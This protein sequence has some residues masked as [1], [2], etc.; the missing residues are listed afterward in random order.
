MWNHVYV[1]VLMW[2]HGQEKG[3]VKRA[4]EQGQI[5]LSLLY[6]QS[7]THYPTWPCFSLPTGHMG[8]VTGPSS[9]D[10]G[11]SV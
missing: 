9:Q 10:C 11:S 6:T 5:P 3:G 7:G 2:V 4:W 1:C 8:L